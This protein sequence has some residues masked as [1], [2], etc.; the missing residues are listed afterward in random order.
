MESTPTDV[1]KKK[2]CDSPSVL[3]LWGESEMKLDEDGRTAKSNLTIDPLRALAKYF[4][5]H[6]EKKVTME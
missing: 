6:N 4:Y 2:L 5:I 3:S 1:D